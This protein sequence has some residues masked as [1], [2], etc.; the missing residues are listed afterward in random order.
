MKTITISVPS[1]PSEVEFT[2]KCMNEI[3]PVRGNCISSGDEAFDKECEDKILKDLDD[4]NP[5]AWCYVR[6]IARWKSFEGSDC[7]GG[8]SYESEED[9]KQPGGYYD[10]MRQAAFANLMQQINSL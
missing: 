7:L 6:V 4:G 1:D 10:D 8:C 5:W 3:T 2:L 9:F